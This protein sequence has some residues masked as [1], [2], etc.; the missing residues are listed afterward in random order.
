MNPEIAS[1]QR[2]IHLEILNLY[3][4]ETGRIQ[5]NPTAIASINATN[6][7]A[8]QAT[9]FADAALVLMEDV[10]QPLNVP[11]ALVRTCLEAQA[12]ANHIIAAK[13]DDRETLAR[14]LIDLMNIS[15][16]FYEKTA[17]QMMKDSMSDESKAL[18]RD[19]A[20][21]PAM[22]SV[23]GI[24]DTSN[25]ES[26]KKQYEKISKNWTYSN[27]IG[28]KKFKDQI[29]LNRSEAQPLQPALDLIYTQACAFVHCDPASIKHGQIL[30]VPGLAHALVLSEL[31][32]VMCFFTALGKEKD[33]DF[34][35]IKIRFNAVDVNEMIFPKKNLPI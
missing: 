28:R 33:Q 32:A 1:E 7:L 10:R 13:G 30:S 22:K 29:F 20:Y 19:R 2:E 31:I 12:R 11:A 24:V 14:E 26:L 5:A 21:F 8:G 27:V 34:I 18:P 25:L 16:A 23:L 4:R 6:F 9:I 3:N 35:N 17:I 15:H